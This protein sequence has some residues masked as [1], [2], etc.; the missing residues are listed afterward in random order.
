M[1]RVGKF[2]IVLNKEDAVY[3][4]GDVVDG[5][6]HLQMKE[7]QT[8]RGVRVRFTG[9]CHTNVKDHEGD[10]A[11]DEY[12]VYF[13]NIITVFGNEKGEGQLAGENTYLQP[14]SHEY[15]FS[16]KLPHQN[17]PSSFEFGKQSVR[18]YIKSY[19][20]IHNGTDKAAKKFFTVIKP[21]DLNSNQD[22]LKPHHSDES[23]MFPNM[24]CGGSKMNIWAEVPRIGYLPGESIL[25]RGAIQNKTRRP[26]KE[27]K[28]ILYQQIQYRTKKKSDTTFRAIAVLEKQK[29]VSTWDNDVLR[30]PSCVPS[31][32]DGCSLI[33]VRYILRVL[34][35]PSPTS[36]DIAVTF[37]ITIGTEPP[38]QTPTVTSPEMVHLGFPL[39]STPPEPVPLPAYSHRS[40][41]DCV[42]GQVTPMDIRDPD[43]DS[44]RFAPKYCFYN[45]S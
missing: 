15:P 26:I 6:I 28:A 12:E 21:L 29:N 27:T 40:F 36:S 37:E 38:R 34:V 17:L 39:E 24:C 30:I 8:C 14:G 44:S 41:V 23:K 1:V 5:V 31:E 3:Y 22:W 11:D 16:Y 33:D 9:E 42:F 7:E 20:D 35:N 43:P 25:I 2:E 19:I 13:D 4:A 45:F 10:S 18:Y 32:L